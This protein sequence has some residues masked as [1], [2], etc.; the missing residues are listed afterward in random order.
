MERN[1]S[2]PRMVCAMA[3]ERGGATLRQGVTD[4]ITAATFEELADSGYARMSMDAIARRAGVGKAALYR[5]WTSK[6]AMLVDLIGGAV[7]SSLPATPNTGALRTD[8]REMFGNL[9][10]QLSHPLV[11]RIGRARHRAA[12]TDRE[13]APSRG[14]DS[15]AGR[16][17]SG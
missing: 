13:T 8:L 14:V 16:D 5:R 6:E 10:T 2:V 12:G 7:R 1:R 3:N 15:V 9:R 4:A 17:R 11:A